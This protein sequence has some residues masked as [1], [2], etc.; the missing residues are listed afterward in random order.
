MNVPYDAGNRPCLE[1]NVPYD[2]ENH[3][4]HEAN[5][6]YGVGNRPS[7]GR[8]GDPPSSDQHVGYARNHP[9]WLSNVVYEAMNCLL[10]RADGPQQAGHYLQHGATDVR[11]PA[12]H[13]DGAAMDSQPHPARLYEATQVANSS[14]IHRV[15][16]QSRVHPS[17]PPKR[18]SIRLSAIPAWRSTLPSASHAN[19][20]LLWHRRPGSATLTEVGSPAKP[21]PPLPRAI[22]SAR[23]SPG[24]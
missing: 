24:D 8:S 11:H 6:P 15:E 5:A 4:H 1:K 12:S 21:L 14:P 10:R 13:A 22:S 3:H 23:P 19:Y 9:C 16:T 17:A 20:S 2:A 7:R 18:H